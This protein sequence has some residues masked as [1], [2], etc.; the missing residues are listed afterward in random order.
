SA[1]YI[2]YLSMKNYYDIL[3]ISKT[4][5]LEEIKKAYRELIKKHHPD[6]NPHNQKAAHEMS[7]LLNEAYSFLAK[8]VSLGTQI[9]YKTGDTIIIKYK[10]DSIIS[11]ENPHFDGE[12][13]SSPDGRYIVIWADYNLE[14]MSG[15][16]G[17]RDRGM[18]GYL[19]IK[20]MKVIKQGKLDR[21]NDGKIA[22]NGN[23]ILNDWLFKSPEQLCSTFY[24]FSSTGEIIIQHQVEANIRACDISY[25]GRY[26][27][28]QT[29]SDTNINP[30]NDMAFPDWS[31]G[32]I[33]CIFDL[34]S[35]K[36]LSRFKPVLLRSYPAFKFDVSGINL[37][38]I[39]KEYDIEHRYSFDGTFLDESKWE[40]EK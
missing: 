14:G 26:A 2:Y 3:G 10:S 22:D 11:I 30:F 33:V 24:A 8:P 40:K 23:F 4:A 18:G 38:L 36:M 17:C 21:P 29:Y 12:Y 9:E 5:S 28:C 6:A 34:E 37:H 31:D 15:I 25:D 20:D 27:V 1:S 19:L 39:Y 32:D 7:Q 35:K 16:S 13:A